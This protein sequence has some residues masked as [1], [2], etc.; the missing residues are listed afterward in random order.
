MVL[1][2]S[3][4][5]GA[6]MMVVTMLIWLVSCSHIDA[7]V[8]SLEDLSY[9]GSM[10]TADCQPKQNAF[11]SRVRTTGASLNSAVRRSIQHAR[12]CA[13]QATVH[14]AISMHT[15]TRARTPTHSRYLVDVKISRVSADDF[16]VASLQRIGQN[17]CHFCWSR[18]TH[19][20]EEGI[21]REDEDA[22]AGTVQL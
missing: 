4:L 1:V 22:R 15:H 9:G 18:T 14:D 3:A 8:Q 11:M 10:G 2:Q 21:A 20:C 5:E 7:T 19:I 16:C 6:L 17:L 13:P 12:A